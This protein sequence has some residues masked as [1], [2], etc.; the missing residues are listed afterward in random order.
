M[1][2]ENF[3]TESR[4][5]ANTIWERQARLLP[6]RLAT[7]VENIQ[8]LRRSIEDAKRD[9]RQWAAQSREE[10]PAADVMG[11]K[12]VDREERGRER[13]QGLYRPGNI[14][15]TTCLIDILRA[16]IGTG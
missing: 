5:D 10:D 13:A 7:M 15:T 12:T 11:Y 16:A 2:W 3:L 6:R 4:G 1:P 14:G 8:L 9:A